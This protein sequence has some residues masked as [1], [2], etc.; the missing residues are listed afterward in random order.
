[1]TEVTKFDP[2]AYVDK[3][4]EKIKASLIDVIPDDQWNTMLRAEITQFFESKRP[5]Y[6]G[7]P[8]QPSEFHRVVMSVIEDETKTRVKELLNSPEWTSHWDGTKMQAADE[9]ARLVRENSAAIM[10]K[11]L[12]A[13]ITQVV[14]RMRFTAQ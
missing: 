8:A 10:A 9:I 1:M 3:I 12:E 7:G 14:D 4:R 5:A 2:N 13:A 11:W 6:H